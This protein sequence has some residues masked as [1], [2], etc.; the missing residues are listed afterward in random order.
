MLFQ[1]PASESNRNNKATYY[2]QMTERTIKDLPSLTWRRLRLCWRKDEIHH[3]CDIDNAAVLAWLSA[4]RTQ[5]QKNITLCPLHSY[6]M[7][8]PISPWCENCGN[9]WWLQN[10]LRALKL[11]LPRT[12]STSNDMMPFSLHGSYKKK[13][14]FSCAS[15]FSVKGHLMCSIC[16]YM[17]RHQAKKSVWMAGESQK[18]FLQNASHFFI[19]I[20][21]CPSGT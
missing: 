5:K 16:W 13:G 8:F 6:W 7:N 18:D 3:R 21:N 10:F 2:I 4:H 17:S 19:S 11:H 9:G 15:N 12:A 20:P 14:I 1:S